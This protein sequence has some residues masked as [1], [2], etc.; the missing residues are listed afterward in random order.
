MRLLP[1]LLA[2]AALAPAQPRVRDL[3]AGAADLTL[4]GR[5]EAGEFGHALAAGDVNGDGV[6]DLIV[7]APR[8]A[9]PGRTSA[10]RVQVF[11]GRADFPA[12]LDLDAHAPDLEVLGI[13]AGDQLGTGVAAGDFNGDGIDDL[14]L[15]AQFSDQQYRGDSG[16]AYVIYGNRAFPPGL[17]RD[18]AVTPADVTFWGRV[19]GDQMGQAVAAGDV[20]GDGRA[21]V[22]LGAPWAHPPAGGYA[23]E[24]YVV[25][26][27]SDWPPQLLYDLLNRP[28]DITVLGPG[29]WEQLG[30]CVR[31]LD[32][33]SDPTPDLVV[34]APFAHP[35]GI[36]NAGE[37][38][39]VYGRNPFPAPV[40]LDLS[41]S[42]ADLTIEGIRSYDRCGWSVDGGD[43]NGDGVVD[44]LLGAFR[45][46]PPGGAQAGEVYLQRMRRDFPPQHVIGFNAVTPTLRVWGDNAE[47]FTGYAVAAG[48]LDG[49]GRADLALSAIQ[50]TAAG[51]ARAGRVHV[52]QAWRNRPDGTVID[53]NAGAADLAIDGPEP[54]GE[55]GFAL[56]A[57]DL[58]GDN[59]R[60][61]VIGE[62]HGVRETIFASGRVHVLFG[63]PLGLD[64]RPPVGGPATL[65]LELPWEAGRLFWGGLAILPG[66][67]IPLGDGRVFPAGP[68]P[69]LFLTLSGL[70]PGFYGSLDAAGRAAPGFPVPAAPPL[71]GLTIYGAFVTLDGGGV[72]FITNRRPVTFAGP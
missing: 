4:R 52:V 54:W 71:A 35:R 34:S 26:G 25:F 63:G 16:E 21:D 23:G 6:R 27:R 72:R 22:V 56:L 45:A 24:A 57:A 15:G 68:D 42:F 70:F 47:D 3:A 10:G 51:R 38:Y 32:V 11:Y 17:V 60:D 14:L 28:A 19:Q 12:F 50:A 48:D 33:G 30:W 64:R 8:S 2:L 13:D 18:L 58:N 55:L 61:L 59:V 43:V 40:V 7:G 36:T 20:N 1:V 5:I 41:R 46:D 39:V 67:G 44:L 31:V 69:L 37:T 65:S 29:P 9:A 66:P 49:D 53:L 62:D